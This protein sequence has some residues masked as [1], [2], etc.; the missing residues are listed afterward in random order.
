MELNALGD[1]TNRPLRATLYNK[2]KHDE[3]KERNRDNAYKR[4]NFGCT[5]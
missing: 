4:V 2:T 5:I 3:V 1:T